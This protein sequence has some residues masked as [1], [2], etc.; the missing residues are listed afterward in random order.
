VFGVKGDCNPRMKMRRL[1]IHNGDAEAFD[2]YF[3]FAA[4]IRLLY[5]CRRSFSS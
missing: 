2:S 4:S 5:D 1:G 3:R